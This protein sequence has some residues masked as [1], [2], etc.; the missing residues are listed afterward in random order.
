[1]PSNER[2][3][4]YFYSFPGF[5]PFREWRKG[6]ADQDTKAAIDARIARFAG[7]N[8]GDSEPI[9]KGAS[10]SKI[11]LGPGYRIYYGVDGRKVIL[12]YGGDKSTQDSDIKTALESWRQY[13]ERK[14]NEKKNKRLSRGPS[15]RSKK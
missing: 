3:V 15:R 10:E 8:F 13:K 12:L 2:S 5:A 1:M 4:Q 11:D 6:F 14:K 9:G 7:G